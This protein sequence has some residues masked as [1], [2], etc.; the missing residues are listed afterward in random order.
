MPR[1]ITINSQKGG[2]GK[3]TLALNLYHYFA[4]EGVRVA[5]VDS[6]NQGTLTQLWEVSEFQ[7][8]LQLIPRANVDSWEELPEIDI[9][10]L[11]IDTAPFIDSQLPGIF[12][13]S[14]IILIPCRASGADILATGKTVELVKQSGKRAAVLLTQSIHGTGFN[15]EARKTLKGYGLPVLS[16]EMKMRV[17]YARSLDDKSG[18]YTSGNNKAIEEIEGIANE[19]INLVNYG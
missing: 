11:I 7:E 2:T 3:S 10:I 16:T 6:D 13:I 19:L 12:R 17:D 8:G 4:R 9:D 15:K 5:L 18:I 1:I 14:D